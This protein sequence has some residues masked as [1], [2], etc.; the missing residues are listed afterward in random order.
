MSFGF[1]P[2]Y[3]SH[4]Q[5]QRCFCISYALLRNLRGGPTFI[6]I[7]NLVRMTSDMDFQMADHLQNIFSTDGL[8]RVARTPL[9]KVLAERFQN[10]LGPDGLGRVIRTL[11]PEVILIWKQ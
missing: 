2:P 6:D 7:Y 1:S 9:E 5:T 11:L 4:G 8:G 3:K 10:I